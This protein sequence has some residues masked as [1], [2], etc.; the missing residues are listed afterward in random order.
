MSMRTKNPHR[1]A[2]VEDLPQVVDA[3]RAVHVEAEL[4]QLERQVALDARPIDRLDQ[5]QVLARRRFGRRERRDAFAEIV[6][7]GQQ[8]LRLDLP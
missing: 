5:L 7:R 8:P 3:D 1:S 2:A 4:R 6:E